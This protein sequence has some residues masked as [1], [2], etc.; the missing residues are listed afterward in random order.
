MWALIL[1][2]RC[3]LYNHRCSHAPVFRSTP[4]DYSYL[5]N[6]MSNNQR[7]AALLEAQ[8]LLQNSRTGILSTIDF[9]SGGPFTS[10]V[11]IASSESGYPIF[12]LSDLARHTKCLRAD[13]RASLLVHP[14]LPQQNDA[15]TVCRATISGAVQLDLENGDQTR[16]IERHDHARLYAG[17]GDFRLWCLVPQH[18]YVVGGFGSIYDFNAAEFFSS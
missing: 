7:R 2:E 3:F 5:K 12:L 17:F 4:S 18:V 13:H 6:T 15:L 14:P 10:L 1:S 8:Q 11:N 9:E 16:F